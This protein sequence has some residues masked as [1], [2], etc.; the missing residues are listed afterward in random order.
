MLTRGLLPGEPPEGC[1][2]VRCR[3]AGRLTFQI[4]VLPLRLVRVVCWGCIQQRVHAH[5]N[6]RLHERVGELVQCL[7]P[8][9]AATASRRD[10]YWT[11]A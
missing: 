5:D 4:E 1:T 8:H 3:P 11:Y 2:Q 6:R 7:V 10:S 9:R